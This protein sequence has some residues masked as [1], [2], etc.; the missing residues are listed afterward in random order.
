M[1]K[2]IITGLKATF[3]IHFIVGL[4]LGIIFLLFPIE[5]GTLMGM[6]IMEPETWRL[7]GAAIMGFTISSIFAAR[8]KEWEKVKILVEAE[9]VWTILGTIVIGYWLIFA[10]GPV[11]G[12]LFFIIL[13][14]FAVAFILFYYQQEK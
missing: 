12:W 2:E 11:L 4:I 5:L 14:A 7:L 6:S 3:L 9:I 1:N 13:T 10:S 8:E